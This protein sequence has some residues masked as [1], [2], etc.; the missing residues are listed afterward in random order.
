MSKEQYDALSEE[1]QKFIRG[2][3]KIARIAVEANK[4]QGRT[5]EQIREATKDSVRF[6]MPG[7]VQKE[8]IDAIMIS[9]VV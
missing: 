7:A 4:R 8:N 3:M 6:Q 2:V 9:K 5:R 1:E